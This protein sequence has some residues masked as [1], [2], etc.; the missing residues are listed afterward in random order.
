MMKKIEKK[1][2]A[3]IGRYRMIEKNDVVVAGV[4]G[5]ADSV[6]LLFVLCALREKLG[7][8]V[9]V[10]H[11][12][13]LL[14]GKDADE[15]EKYVERLCAGLGVPCRVFREDVELFARNGK[16]SL[17]E[18]GRLVRRSAFETMCRENGGTKIATA[19]HR[20]DNAETVL[21]NMARGTGIRGLC[22]IRP[23][24]GKWIRPLL[25][26]TRQEIEEGLAEEGISWRTDATNEE[27]EYTRNRIRHR[28]LPELERQVNAGTS[29]HLGELAE[30][31]G[32]IW[33]YMQE[34]TDEAWKLCVKELPAG[35]RFIIEEEPFRTLAPALQK[36]LIHRCICRA[37]GRERDIESVHVNKV[38]DLFLRQTGRRLD[39]PGR[40]RAL[41][42]YGAVEL[43]RISADAAREE[44]GKADADIPESARTGNPPMG[45][46]PLQIPGETYFPETGERILCR[47]AEQAD[48]ISA[49]EIPQKSY[50]KLI[51]YD[52][53]K[54]SLSARTRQAGDYLTVDSRGNRQKLKSY[55]IN[56][57][58]PREEREH[59]LLIADGRHIV[60]IPGMR[61][62]SA[63]QVRKETGKILEIKI[64]KE[65]NNGRDDQGIDSG[66]RSGSEDP[67]AGRKDQQRL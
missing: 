36:M 41:R 21:L 54:Y 34:Q 33:D 42:T 3:L 39:L 7:F 8:Q 11:V 63:Y 32:E 24:Y 49:K 9:Q 50:T 45:E 67:G 65:K 57:K 12:N 22:G 44:G 51:D 55:F 37:A 47:F 43:Q 59:K 52:I 6:C 61:M 2:E 10:C 16:Y 4:S 62:S 46:I 23:V 19:H 14:R 66:R 30:Q 48:Y 26:L 40:V 28:I 64:T 58:V 15:D 27:D 20:D 35:N 13:H 17:E 5:G 53:I 60:W 18:A 56:E 1:T 31:A 25:C 29:R 38:L